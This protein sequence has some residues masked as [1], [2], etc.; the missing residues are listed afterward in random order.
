MESAEEEGEHSLDRRPTKYAYV[1]ACMRL[2]SHLFAV[3]LDSEDGG[4]VFFRNVPELLADYMALHLRRNLVFT[5][6]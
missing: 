3:L 6:S 5:R 4:S 1:S 2:A